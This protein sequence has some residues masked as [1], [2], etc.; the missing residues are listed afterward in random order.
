[1]SEATEPPRCVCSSARPSTGRAMA[2]NSTR[3][4][5][6]AAY[7][8]AAWTNACSSGRTRGSIVCGTGVSR[9]RRSAPACTHAL[10]CRPTELDRDDGVVGAVCHG[11]RVA[12]ETC[13]IELEALR[14]GHEARQ[15]HDCRRARPARAEAEGPAH[16]GTLREAA[17]HDTLQGHRERV[18]EG[19]RALERGEERF[20]V[21][22]GDAAEA[23]PVRPA[24]RQRQRCPW[25][26]PEQPPLRIEDVEQGEEVVLVRPP[27]VQEHERPRRLAGRGADEMSERL[28]G[29][30]R[31]ARVAHDARGSGS[32]VSSGSTCARSCSNAGGR[33]SFSPRCSGSSS[34]EK[35]G[36]SVAI[37]KRTPLGSRK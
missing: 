37:S 13:Q 10:G 5:A 36:P 14:L 24:R 17:E 3:A 22:C 25:R 32:G 34:T 11:D 20:G 2:R 8:M 31:Y 18:E 33:I 30:R 12:A 19:G 9:Q 29:R 27:A 1:M 21:G 15:S 16:H 23:V 7:G 35:P 28:H 6:T 4:E 26:D